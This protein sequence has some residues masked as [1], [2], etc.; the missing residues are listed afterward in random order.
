MPPPF[1]LCLLPPPFSPSLFHY[2]LST[3]FLPSLSFL[4]NLLPPLYSAFSHSSSSFS[5]F[6]TSLSPLSRSVPPL[7]HI[8]LLTP[9][10][11]SYFSSMHIPLFLYR[12]I[13]SSFSPSLF[14]SSLLLRP[15]SVMSFFTPSVPFL[16][17]SLPSL[18]HPSCCYYLFSYFLLSLHLPY[19]LHL[20]FPYFP[21]FLYFCCFLFFSLFIAFL[22]K[23]R[24]FVLSYLTFSVH[25][26]HSIFTSPSDSSFTP[27]CPVCP[28][29]IPSVKLTVI[30]LWSL[31]NGTLLLFFLS[32][33]TVVVHQ[34]LTPSVILPSFF[35]LFIPLCT[36]S[37]SL[38]LPAPQQCHTQTFSCSNEINS[39]V[40]FCCLGGG[41]K[42]LIT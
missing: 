25:L 38:N 37:L 13:F 12:G 32:L 16:P 29:P 8:F 42:C 22:S 17:S 30:L 33:L 1:I 36:S 18:L 31:I 26:F 24:S 23:L 19:F 27:L 6:K 39:I 20:I 34:T 5:P 40:W 4:R 35:C 11:L 10:Y 2:L 28:H 41:I 7:F 9:F 14:S 3:S 21:V 15:S